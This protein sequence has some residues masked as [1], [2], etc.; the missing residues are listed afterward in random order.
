MLTKK[1]AVK[2]AARRVVKKTAGR[3]R[4]VSKLEFDHSADNVLIAIGLT[5][6]DIQSMV[7]WTVET[8]NSYINMSNS[9]SRIVEAIESRMTADAK[10][11]R[12]IALLIQQGYRALVTEKIAT[13]LFHPKSATRHMW[14]SIKDMASTC[15]DGLAFIWSKISGYVRISWRT[16]RLLIG[17]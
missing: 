16:I 2:K 4:K 3:S 7:T 1:K 8:Y 9:S 6:A 14:V 15:G 10:Y 5:E 12:C 11:A 13:P 17:K